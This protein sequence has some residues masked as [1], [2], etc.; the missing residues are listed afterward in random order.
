MCSVGK[1]IEA[2]SRLLVA[3]GRGEW[4]VTANGMGRLSPIMTS[5][6][7]NRAYIMKH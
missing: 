2:E 3:C 1:S 7:I 5:D 4:G 6:L